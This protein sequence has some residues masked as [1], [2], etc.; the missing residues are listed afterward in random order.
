MT[1]P[2]QS[3]R[4]DESISSYGA[5]Y[6]TSAEQG[7]YSPPPTV[8]P[9]TNPFRNPATNPFLKQTSNNPFRNPA[10]NSFLKQTSNNPFLNRNFDRPVP[11]PEATNSPP[12]IPAKF[13]AESLPP[14]LSPC[15]PANQTERRGRD[16]RAPPVPRKPTQYLTKPRALSQKPGPPLVSQ[17]HVPTLQPPAGLSTQASLA[18]Q[19]Y[20]ADA[21]QDTLN[22]Q[23]GATQQEKYV[24]Q[25]SIA[26]LTDDD[27]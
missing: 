12:D 2:R 24:R 1:F 15:P 26:E 13:L 14:P 19:P 16:P 23:N 6:F 27:W 20:V 3:S 25:F 17:Q 22:M 5:K 9:S 7:Q 11:V 21:L 8:H 18:S 4:Q 10:M